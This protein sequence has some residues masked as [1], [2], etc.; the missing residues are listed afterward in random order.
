MHDA[1]RDQTGDNIDDSYGYPWLFGSQESQQLFCVIWM[2][3]ANR[4]KDEPARL[5]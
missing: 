3:I 5:C 1:P 4:Y 2:K